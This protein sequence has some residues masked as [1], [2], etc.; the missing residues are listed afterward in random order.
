MRDKGGLGMAIPDDDSNNGIK[1]IKDAL[2]AHI[3][4]ELKSPTLPDGIQTLPEL[5]RL[6]IELSCLF[7]R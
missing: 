7:F 1:D 3:L 6:F 2:E 4:R 5:I